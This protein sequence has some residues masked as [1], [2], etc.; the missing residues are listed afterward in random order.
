MRKDTVD[1]ERHIIR[2]WSDGGYGHYTKKE[3]M[4]MDFLERML[5]EFKGGS[6]LEVGPGT[7]QFAKMM[8]ARFDISSYTVLDLEE[9]ISDSQMLLTEAGLECD[10]VVSQDYESLFDKQFDLFVSNVCLPETPDYYRV[11]LCSNVLPRCNFAFII[12]GDDKNEADGYGKWIRDLFNCTF[13]QVAELPTGY[14]S[15]FAI[16]GHNEQD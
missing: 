3:S 6:V 15:T 10:A 14:C 13:S 8:F 12:G 11:N 2:M 5:P 7:G 16:G 4:Y 1:F 9:N